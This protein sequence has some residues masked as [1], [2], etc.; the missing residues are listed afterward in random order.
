MPF[1][2]LRM[3]GEQSLLNRVDGDRL[4][5]G[6]GTN[7]ELRFDDAAVGLEHAAV[8]RQGAGYRLLDRGSVTGTY[9]NG[10]PVADAPLARGD[11]I[12]IGG[13]RLRVAGGEDPA[14]IAAGEPLVL[15]I[16]A[17]ADALPAAGMH[18][19]GIKEQAGGAAR[20]AA[21]GPPSTAT[22]APPGT[23]SAPPGPVGGPAEPAAPPPASPSRAPLLRDVDYVAAYSLRRPLLTKGFLALVLAAAGAAALLALPRTGRLGWFQ[24]GAVHSKHAAL[25]CTQ[26][27][28]PW[29]GPA[30]DQCAACHAQRQVIELVHQARQTAAPPCTDCHPE[31][32]GE[33]ALMA[34]ADG[35][36]V[37][38]HGDLRLAGGGPPRFARAVHGFTTDHPEFSLTL[39]LTLGT[40]AAARAPLAEAAVQVPLAEAVARRADPIALRF[41]HRQHLRAGLRT[42]DGRPA[43]LTCASC[44]PAGNG[45][46]GLAA[47]TYENACATSGCHPLTFD[48]RRPDAKAPHGQPR[49]VRDFLENVYANRAPADA[50]V[51]ELRRRLIR[52][53]DAPPRLLDFSAAAQRRVLD[54]ERYLFGTACRECHRV[55]LDAGPLP[56]VEWVALPPNRLPNARFSHADHKDT[57]CAECHA[58]A[59]ASTTAADVL[60]PGIAVCRSCHGA[61]GGPG[62][63]GPGA[64]RVAARETG[65][66]AGAGAAGGLGMPAGEAP[67]GSGSG[68]TEAGGGV[69]T[70]GSNCTGCHVYHPRRIAAAAG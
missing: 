53:P 20:T 10:R 36:C 65:M 2:L 70:A 41:D 67:A 63:G 37:S 8:E 38:C 62:A 25:A 47:L 39:T 51:R 18:A 26:C 5:I 35:A 22:G 34:V 24:P 42:P 46:T 21:G 17:A 69:R 13:F 64:A 14:A 43:A 1:L 60:E 55:D 3:T 45:P 28:A 7:S 15:E 52:S 58:A 40:A 49:Q 12:G 61:A 4:R 11:T 29:R 54:A 57:R 32:R 9:L 33:A 59:A 48:D 6:R 30:A 66:A 16:R 31:H 23:A 44:H 68:G 19:P 50:T 27:H 56:R